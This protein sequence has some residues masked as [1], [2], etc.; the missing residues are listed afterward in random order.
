[1]DIEIKLKVELDITDSMR[2]FLNLGRQKPS[3]PEPAAPFQRSDPAPAAIPVAEDP[4][5]PQAAPQPQITDLQIKEAISSASARLLECDGIADAQKVA[6][7]FLNICLGIAERLQPGCPKPTALDNAN[8][9]RFLQELDN[10][11]VINGLPA[12]KPF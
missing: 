1:M 12:W 11:Q 8:R 4:T 9:A 5:P 10:I 3:A 2:A 7:Q 6:K